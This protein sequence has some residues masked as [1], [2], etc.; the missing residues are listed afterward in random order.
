MILAYKHGLQ[1]NFLNAF[2]CTHLLSKIDNFYS[3]NWDSNWFFVKLIEISQKPC[4]I[5]W[6]LRILINL[7]WDFSTKWLLDYSRFLSSISIKFG[8]RKVRFFPISVF[9]RFWRLI[10]IDFSSI[11]ILKNCFKIVDFSI[12][13]K[14]DPALL[15]SRHL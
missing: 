1:Q 2:I 7:S 3:L 12:S 8:V 6:L 13:V 15:E 14:I 11:S 10:K 9:W 5:S 4:V